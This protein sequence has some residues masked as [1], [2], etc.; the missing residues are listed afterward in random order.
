MKESLAE[1][2]ERLKEERDVAYRKWKNTIKAYLNDGKK[3]P[4][5]DEESD[6]EETKAMLVRVGDSD[7]HVDGYVD[8]VY[9]ND[10]HGAF[11][12]HLISLDY[13]ECDQYIME[14]ELPKE[15]VTKLLEHIVWE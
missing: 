3:M 11:K 5:V 1:K 15:E 12:F 10:S 8:K 7:Y 13:R 9:Y 2:F 14:W 4:I 6:N